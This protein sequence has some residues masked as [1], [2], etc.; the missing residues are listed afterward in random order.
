MFSMFQLSHRPSVFL[1][2]NSWRCSRKDILCKGI[3]SLLSKIE[4][5]VRSVSASMLP[6]A[7]WNL[8][9]MFLSGKR[10]G[11]PS[12]NS[13]SEQNPCSLISPDDIIEV[14]RRT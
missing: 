3:C 12:W 4:K 1:L 9:Q 6:F 10:M 8:T 2:Y 5:I 13:K 7:D 11:H 14:W